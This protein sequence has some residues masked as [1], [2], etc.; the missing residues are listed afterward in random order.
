VRLYLRDTVNEKLLPQRRI[1]YET[2]ELKCPQSVEC[3]SSSRLHN[4]TN[5]FLQAPFTL[6]WFIKHYVLVA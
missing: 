4:T 3:F 1:E 5:W 2:R 6:Q